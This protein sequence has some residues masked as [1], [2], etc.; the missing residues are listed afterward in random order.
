M[1]LYH[2]RVCMG[3]DTVRGFGYSLGGLDCVLHGRGGPLHTSRRQWLTAAATR[4]ALR[5]TSAEDASSRLPQGRYT[6]TRSTISG[7]AKGCSSSLPGTYGLA[8]G[9]TFPHS[10]Y[11]QGGSGAELGALREVWVR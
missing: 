9:V 4:V 7:L 6:D 8:Q 10:G 3:F 11:N 2:G 5:V 1:N